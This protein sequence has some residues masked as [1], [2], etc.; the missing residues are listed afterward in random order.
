MKLAVAVLSSILLACSV[1]TASPV[2]P[3]IGGLDPLPRNVKYLLE[4]YAEIQDDR[5]QQ[6]KMHQLLKSR[7]DSQREVI[8]IYEKKL[9][10]LKKKPQR[11]GG[12]P[13]HDEKIQKAKLDLEAQY[14][15]FVKLRKEFDECES[16]LGDLVEKEWETDQQIVSL[17]FGTPLN[18]ATV[19]HQASLI[20]ETPSAKNYLEKIIKKQES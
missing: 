10:T 8:M 6:R 11:K 18:V 16:K 7:Y 4:K 2:K 1:T 5:N 17:V 14:S 13:E 20:K 15:K 12:D 3:S 19:A 9:E